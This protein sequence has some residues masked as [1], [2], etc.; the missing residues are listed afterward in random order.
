MD[1]DNS[2]GTTA[3]GAVASSSSAG[4]FSLDADTFKKIHPTE[5]HR[6]F[7]SQGV[8][9]DG[10]EL[11]RFRKAI[12][13]VGVISTAHGSAM[14]RL[15]DTTVICGVKAEVTEPK[16]A[17]PKHGFLVPNVDLPPICSPNSR[18]GPPSEL[19]QTVSEYIDQVVKGSELLN[20]QDLCIEPGHAV[21]VL[22]ADIVCLNHDGNILD[23]ALIALGAALRHVRLPKATY[24]D[25]LGGTVRVAEEKTIA[26]KIRRSLVPV[27]FGVFDS[28][29]PLADPTFDEEPHLSSRI[30]YILSHLSTSTPSDAIQLAGLYNPGGAPVTRAT[31]TTCLAQAKKRAK[32]IL[33][34]VDEAFTDVIGV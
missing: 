23:A 34:L 29:T 32:E 14:V 7:L 16:P 26:L 15:G 13:T 8:R 4:G 6:R 12:V 3:N 31:M 19:A 17:A 10:R 30:S 11:L 5:Y 28:I 24:N 1:V 18:P 22:Y 2:S 33:A 27:T 25:E 20:A 21:W 9:A